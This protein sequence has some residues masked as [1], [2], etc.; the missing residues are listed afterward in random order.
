MKDLGSDDKMSVATLTAKILGAIA[1]GVAEQGVGIIPDEITG[2]IKDV[3]GAGSE[4]IIKGGKGVIKGA[5]GVLKGAG[6]AGKGLLD[7]AA[8][9]FKKKKKD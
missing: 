5:G 2:P 7:G 1:M 9:L 4:V 3:L 6:D 8:G